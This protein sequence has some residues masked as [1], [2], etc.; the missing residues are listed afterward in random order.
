MAQTFVMVVTQVAEVS[1]PW[2]LFGFLKK[3]NERK[4]YYQVNVQLKIKTNNDHHHQIATNC[5]QRPLFCGPNLT[6][7]NIN[8]LWT[9]TN[10][11]YF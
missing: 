3:K 4:I 10:C 5:Q 2:K 1:C 8:N 11:H 9:T 6:F 7:Y